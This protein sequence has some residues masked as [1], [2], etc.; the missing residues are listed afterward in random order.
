M[1]DVHNVLFFLYDQERDALVGGNITGNEENDPANSLTIPFQK[2]K[3]LLARSLQQEIILDSFSSSKETA[4]T[5]MDKQLVRF[6]GKDGMLCLPMVSR[7]AKVGVMVLGIDGQHI[8]CL[9]DQVK[10]LTMLAGQAALA[11]TADH[12]R[13]GETNRLRGVIK[14]IQAVLDKEKSR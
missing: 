12:L 8:D 14:N 7:G 3:S 5:I 6:L 13:Q 4:L 10:L 1:F 2:G 11:L 9:R